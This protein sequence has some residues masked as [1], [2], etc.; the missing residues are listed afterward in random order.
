MPLAPM[1][2]EISK[3]RSTKKEIK[4]KEIKE[5]M[6][7]QTVCKGNLCMGGVKWFGQL[8]QPDYLSWK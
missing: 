6:A 4:R 8:L 5:Q 3:L 7:V 1:T 2:V